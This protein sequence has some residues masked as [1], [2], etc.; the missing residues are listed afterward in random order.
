VRDASPVTAVGPPEERIDT[1]PA[2]EDDVDA[3][4]ALDEIVRVDP[5]RAAFI[6][7]AVAS[8]DCLV[9][10]HGGRVVGYGVLE[11]SFF[12]HGFVSMLYV[13]ASHRRHGAGTALLR[14]LERRCPTEKVFTSTNASNAPMQALLVRAGFEPSGV[15]Y[16]LDPGDPEMIFVRIVR[17]HAG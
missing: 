4:L 14:A 17:A 10:L 2:R 13:A 3:L 1:R 5:G 9:A 11:R 15:V 7:G 8:G 12:A 6:R 16:N